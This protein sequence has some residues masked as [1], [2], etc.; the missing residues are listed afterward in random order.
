M[1]VS[2]LSLF[3]S[4][5]QSYA[6]KIGANTYV[7]FY[8]VLFWYGNDVEFADTPSGTLDLN[9]YRKYREI[10]YPNAIY[11]YSDGSFDSLRSNPIIACVNSDS[12]WKDI[13]GKCLSPVTS[14]PNTGATLFDSHTHNPVSL[15][16][17]RVYNTLAFATG[18][19]LSSNTLATY[20]EQ[21][22]DHTH[23]HSTNN[24]ARGL[25]NVVYGQPDSDG[26]IQG[27]NAIAVDPIL[28]DPQLAVSRPGV[29]DARLRFF[30]KN[31]IVFGNS[32]PSEYYTRND[33]GHTSSAN[34]KIL[35][36]IAKDDN[37]GVLE[38]SNTQ[39]SF[40]ISSNAAPSHNHNTYPSTRKRKSNRT[41]QTAYRLVEAGVHNHRTTY[42]AN[43]ELRSK[44]LKAWI[45][46]SD[47]T[48]IANGVIIAYSIGENT[49]FT[50]QESNSVTLPVNWHF[51]D[52]NNGTP[53][54]RGYYIYANF[55]ESNT[56]HNVVYK[57]SNTMIIHSIDIE[58]N[59]SH[60]H[61]GPTT[62]NEIGLGTATDVGSHTFET[63]LNH[64][65]TISNETTF[66]YSPTDTA[67]V[68]NIR[69]GQSYSYTPPTVGLAFIMYN[70]TIV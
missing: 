50:G 19:T 4:E 35:P 27:V 1:P 34:G 24:I 18:D 36:L 61:L 42:T 20:I 45:T 2:K 55:D 67:N 8:A 51:C 3:K 69:V 23:I 10:Y 11:Y 57:S 33:S 47:E 9:Y 17:T 37:V 64:T 44:I 31:I 52:G 65:H 13:T 32:L 46:T 6:P 29:N 41:N 38:I 40:T 28:R 54:L 48:P 59:G 22:G 60:S 53:D 25:R 43:V 12:N 68:T 66:L 56:Y 63:S 58:A 39:L 14:L 30:P 49:L 7:P 15:N 16:R 62:G 5:G 70:N 21:K 26:E